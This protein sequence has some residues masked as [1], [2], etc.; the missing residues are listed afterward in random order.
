MV[1]LKLSHSG[2]YDKEEI[3][4]DLEKIYQRVR[5]ISRTLKPNEINNLGLKLSTQS[6]VNYISESSK[7]NG[8]FSIWA[9]KKNLI[10]K[11]KFASTELF[12]NL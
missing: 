8:S 5:Q 10:R 3:Q 6:L 1:K 2:K 11:L 4:I 9:K 12:G 7:I